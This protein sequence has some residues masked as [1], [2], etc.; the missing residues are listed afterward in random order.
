MTKAERIAAFRARNQNGP[1][2]RAATLKAIHLLS[3]EEILSLFGDITAGLAFL[4][5]VFFFMH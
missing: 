2:A 4:V 1:R 3:A 5:S